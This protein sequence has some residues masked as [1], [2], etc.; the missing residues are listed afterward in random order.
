MLTEKRSF[1]SGQ[2]SDDDPK[3][4]DD[5]SSLNIMNARMAISQNG[6]MGRIENVPG[7]TLVNQ[8]VYPPY[9]TS[10]TIGTAI[11][12][13]NSRLLF[14]NYNTFEDHGIYCYDPSVNTIYAVLYD[15]QVTGGLGFSRDSLIHSA[16]VENGLLYWCDSTNNEPRRININAGIEMNLAGTFPDVTP[17]QAPMSQY[18]LYWVRRQP[19]LPLSIE[20]DTDATY[21]NNFIK[22]E[23]FQF[24]WRYIYR[25]YETSTLSGL[26]TLANYNDLDDTFNFITVSAPLNETI[27]QDV[28]QVDYVVKFLNGGKSFVFKSWNKNLPL[29]ELAIYNH[30][31]AG[32][33]LSVDFYN[34]ITGIALDDAYS[35]K[36]YDSLPIYA[37]TIEMARFRSFMANY[38]IGYDTPTTTSLSAAFE[39]QTEGGTAT[40]V[41]WELQWRPSPFGSPNLYY[42]ILLSGL[43]VY[44]GY[45]GHL[46]FPGPTGTPATPPILPTTADYPTEMAFAGLNSAEVM[47]YLL[48]DPAGYLSFSATAT[49]IS[50]T[51][52]PSTI[53]LVGATA[54]KS[55]ASYQPAIVFYDFA[56]RKCG[57]LTS[58]NLIKTTPDRAYNSIA[59]TTALNWTLSNADAVNEIPDW[60]Y[61][62]SIVVTKCLRT[63]FFLESRV[64]DI[65]YATKDTNGDY[66]FTATAYVA[67]HN[68][69]AIDI[70]LL[71]GY[72]MGY[73][74]AEG[75]LVKVY[76]DAVATI[77][78]LSIIAQDGNWIVAELQN[79]GSL[80]GAPKTDVL[81]EIYT[82]YKP[83]TSEPFYEVAQTF[84]ISDPTTASR[85]YSAVAGSIGGDITLLNRS[86]GSVNYLTENMSP[87]DTYPYNWNTDSGRPNFIDN[88]GQQVLTNSIAWSNTLIH[89]SKVNGLST[90]DAL[91]VK[92]ISLECGDISKLQVA[93]K[94]SDEQGTIML[95]VCEHQT[96]SCYLGE[97]QLVGS[98]EN[99]FIASSPGV[100]GTVNILQGS[101]GTT[102]PESVFEYLGLV[103]F[104]DL[105]NGSVI[106]YSQSGLEPV[107]RY[108]MSRFFQNYCKGYLAANANNLDNING[109][110]HIRQTINPFTKE[111]LSTLPGLIYENYANTLPSYTSVPSYATSILDRFDI[112]DQLQKTMSFQFLE[113]KWGNNYEWVAEWSDYLQ[114]QHYQFKDGNLYITDSDTTNWNT[115]FGVQYPV[116][117]CCTGNLNPSL[118]KDLMNVAIEGNAAPDF[119]V[120]MANYPN[121]Q[122]TDLALTDTDA[123]GNPIWVNQQGVFDATWLCDR[124]SPNATGTADQKLYT[125]DPLTDFAL[126]FMF[127]FQQYEQLFYCNFVNIGYDA[128]KGNQNIV[129]VINK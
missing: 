59:Y 56:G 28:L 4:L 82:P 95:A 39:T 36:P 120:A 53:T 55:D 106:Q 61:S 47:S 129:N 68:G 40:G 94:I 45:Y 121:E 38:T 9:G 63:R 80:V 37:Q 35:V 76:I 10:Q 17:Y 126:F 26:S 77:Y 109:F 117:I 100:I 15:S 97:V 19:G 115:V 107:S 29:D 101:F 2:N 108:K 25:D 8:Q 51:N 24:Y 113:N 27:Q 128:S 58:D 30:N 75:D 50:M 22:N 42:V 93:N 71:N 103:F 41:W 92:E 125:G 49:T 1:F 31:N 85:E 78:T 67:T 112:Y 81:F 13:D 74:F 83:S 86:D 46:P 21:D 87:N 66:V 99:A 91:D 84:L 70:T 73:T 3:L 119:S 57:L 34:D 105:H 62:Y 122:I 23:A 48:L 104:I 43:G 54:F 118:L 102:R 18:V 16:R 14:F 7:N 20:K 90:Y 88:I 124:L 6:R 79:I 96:A 98:Q 110:H 123:S 11:D 12:F 33:A 44:D 60:A 5:K 64:K 52:P 111:V 116:R 69:V 65:K 72:G 114:N 127:E 32:I 89:G